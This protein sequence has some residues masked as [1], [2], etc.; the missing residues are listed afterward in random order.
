MARG[1]TWRW[2]VGGIFI[3]AALQIVLINLATEP[4]LDDNVDDG[5]QPFGAAHDHRE[6][7]PLYAVSTSLTSLFLWKRFIFNGEMSC[8]SKIPHIPL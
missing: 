7:R 3:V 5:G 8:S 6:Q 2:I 4:D 1:S